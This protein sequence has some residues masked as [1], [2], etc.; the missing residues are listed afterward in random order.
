MT[1]ILDIR[2][3]GPVTLLLGDARLILEELEG[4]ADL[5][6]TDPP[7]LLTSGG[8]N[9]VSMAGIFSSSV[10][11]NNGRL[12]PVVRWEE[13]AGPILRACRG[14]AHTYVMCN[15]KHL[16]QAITAFT[17]AGWRL[18]NILA[19]NKGAPTRNRW[20]MK[21]LEFTVFLFRGKA[22]TICNPGS[23]QLFSCPRPADRWHRTQKPVELMAHYIGNSARP[24]QMVLDPFSGSG[25]TLKAAMMT[26][27]RAIGI[28][29]DPDFFQRSGDDLAALWESLSANDPD[30][31][32]ARA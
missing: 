8:K 25:A 3:I 11:A 12:M 31:L 2:R 17:S 28:E 16:G 6:V 14:D 30:R 27:R 24:G 1:A 23:T 26:G 18:H 20:Y 9:S 19:W 13:I 32:S 21:N 15:D 29:I 5:V 7:Y 10:Y 4:Q 22:K